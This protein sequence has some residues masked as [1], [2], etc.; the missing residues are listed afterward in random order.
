MIFPSPL[1]I[2]EKNFIE[3]PHD[4]P[5]DVVLGFQLLQQFLDKFCLLVSSSTWNLTK[6]HLEDESFNSIQV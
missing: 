4:N 1:L 3:N 5:G 6:I 2:V